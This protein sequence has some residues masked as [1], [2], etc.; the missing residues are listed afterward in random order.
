MKLEVYEY[1]INDKK[2]GLYTG[3]YT[4]PENCPNKKELQKKYHSHL[5]DRY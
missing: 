1:T 4:V 2:A 3:S 5:V